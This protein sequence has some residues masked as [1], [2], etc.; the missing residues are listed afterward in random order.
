MYNTVL[1]PVT[2]WLIFI[3]VLSVV[4]ESVPSVEM[5][6]PHWIWQVRSRD[7]GRWWVVSDKMVGW[8]DGRMVG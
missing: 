4:L 2:W 1:M 7:R 3:N 5:A 8:W 6:V